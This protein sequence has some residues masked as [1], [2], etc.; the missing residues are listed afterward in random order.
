MQEMLLL[1]LGYT[2]N[3]PPPFRIN[4]EGLIT[5]GERLVCGCVF[6]CVRVCASGHAA[7]FFSAEKKKQSLYFK[8][9]SLSETGRSMY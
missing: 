9:E 4:D 1:V 6:Q 3:R 7:I 8:A 5:E 2:A